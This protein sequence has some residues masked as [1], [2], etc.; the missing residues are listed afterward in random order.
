V[1]QRMSITADT[2]MAQLSTCVFLSHARL[3]AK[4]C[5]VGGSSPPELIKSADDYVRRV[6]DQIEMI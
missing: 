3:K 6:R 5:S 4:Q 2:I 1:G